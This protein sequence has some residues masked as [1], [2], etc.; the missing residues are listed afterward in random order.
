MVITF[1]SD[2]NDPSS[3]PGTTFFLSLENDKY[4]I[5]GEIQADQDHRLIMVCLDNNSSSL[6]SW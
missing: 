2:P 6:K 4:F 5:N 3:S 1:G